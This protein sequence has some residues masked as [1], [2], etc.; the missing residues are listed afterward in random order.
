MRLCTDPETVYISSFSK[1]L[2]AGLRVGYI[3]PGSC[4]EKAFSV[5]SSTTMS[6]PGLTQEI[7][8]GLWAGGGYDRHLCFLRSPYVRNVSTV[9][10]L[11]CKYFPSGIKVT[12]PSGSFYL[13]VELPNPLDTGELSR[14]VLEKGLLLVPGSVF[15]PDGEYGNY[16]R[17]GLARRFTRDEAEQAVREL[18]GLISL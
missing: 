3:V 7:V 15:S 10:S 9:Y 2:G 16:L 11:I 18:A 1:T 4:F 5:I 12:R 17:L 6:A 14:R 8:S 13:W